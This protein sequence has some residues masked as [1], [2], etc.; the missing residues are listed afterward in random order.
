MQEFQ[1]TP[2]HVPVTK[3]LYQ[4]APSARRDFESSINET[5]AE[6]LW[7]RHAIDLKALKVVHARNRSTIVTQDDITRPHLLDMP[8]LGSTIKTSRRLFDTTSGPFAHTVTSMRT[9]SLVAKRRNHQELRA[10]V[11]EII[12]REQLQDQSTDT[13]HP[14]YLARIRAL[15]GAILNPL[16]GN[17]K[18]FKQIMRD[19]VANL[20]RK[21]PDEFWFKCVDVLELLCT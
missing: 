19:T 17:D 15:D 13:L 1:N 11:K 16:V 12:S 14:Q 18:I 10:R 6:T 3:R 21:H 5:R 8:D 2:A 4:L 7:N 20:E 9:T